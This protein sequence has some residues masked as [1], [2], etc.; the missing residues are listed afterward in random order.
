MTIDST[1]VFVI[2]YAE[3]GKRPKHDA[4]LHRPGYC[5]HPF[6]GTPMRRATERELAVMEPCSDCVAHEATIVAERG[7]VEPL[8]PEVRE[9]EEVDG[10]SKGYWPEAVAHLVEA[11][12][13]LQEAFS[14]VDEWRGLGYQAETA[15]SIATSAI[16]LMYAA[17]AEG[18]KESGL[19]AEGEDFW[20]TC[21]AL[22]GFALGT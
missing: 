17:L 3:L 14:T 13:E 2:D 19:D 20:K 16:D 21:H 12:R 11:K 22:P 18:M 1:I 10:E 15:L 7:T 8:P 6:N 4:K 5:A 9:D